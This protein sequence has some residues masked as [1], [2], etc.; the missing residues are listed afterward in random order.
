MVSNVIEDGPS[1]GVIGGDDESITTPISTKLIKNIHPGAK[2]SN[3]AGMT[4]LKGSLLFSANNGKKGTELWQSKGNKKTT[5]LF[6][7][8]NKGSE[9]SNPTEFSVRQSKVY[10]SANGGHK[11]QELWISDGE[12]GGTK[13]L[14]DINPGQAS[15]FPT[16]LLWLNQ[17]LFFAANY[18]HHGRELW[19]Y[20]K[21][22]QTSSLVLDIKTNAKSGSNPSELTELYGQIIFAAND[23]IYGRE[24]WISDGTADRTRLLQ[25]INP[26]GFSSNPSDF[27]LLN[28]RLYF[29]ADSYLL[30][31]TQIMRLEKNADKVN[32][33]VGSLG[34]AVGSDPSELHASEDALFYAAATK[35]EPKEEESGS[36]SSVPSKDPGGF[37]IAKD[38]LE[39]RALD[40]I[41]DYNEN[42]DS[43]RDFDDPDFINLARYWADALA[44]SSLIEIND[45]SLARDWNQ[46]YQP[47]SNQSFSTSLLIR[48][49]EEVPSNAARRSTTSTPGNSNGGNSESNDKNSLGHELWISNGEANGNS[50]LMD[51]NPGPASSNPS[52][53]S[54][55]GQKTYFSADNGRHGEELWMSDGT[56]EGTI[57]L[58]DIN[59]GSKNSS[60]RD[61]VEGPD[62]I[63]FSAIQDKVG[64]EL[65]RLND[66]DQSTTR[67]VTAGKGKKKVKAL[68]DSNGEFR[69]ELPNQFGKAKADRI[70]G[71]KPD[72]G[73]KLALSTNA[74]RGLSEINLVTV[75][76]GRQLRVQQK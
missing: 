23:E 16:D 62:G 35:L 11:G 42:I 1:D 21:N 20:S 33:I 50:L 47:L 65:W 28:N 74:F 12:K 24:L 10:F 3:P 2:G 14:S 13:L 5:I 73:D 51:I 53:F 44:T 58:T 45:I 8:I 71:F 46:Y 70:T 40:Y 41:D 31:G 52:D 59:E 29:T 67:I 34:D 15:S 54:T 64:R 63:Y 66:D 61:I 32:A 30:G 38:G 36:D 9:S 19:T 49:P 6:K 60:P 56:P 4:L 57:R 68:D 75:S 37:M 25:D 39:P 18:G 7:D 43:Y 22:D 69:F 76:S 27:N 48:I 72:A 26:G 17:N 55:I